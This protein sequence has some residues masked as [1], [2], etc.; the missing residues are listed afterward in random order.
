MKIRETIHEL[1][2]F[3]LETSKFLLL[4][5]FSKKDMIS[6]VAPL[7]EEGM[8]LSVGRTDGS[9]ISLCDSSI[10]RKHG[11]LRVTEQGWIEI[12]D[13][14][15]KYGTFVELQRDLHDLTNLVL[16]KDRFIF[17]LDV[18]K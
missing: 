17:Y 12:R 10:S 11:S 6:Y 16:A 8:E 3:S 4:E 7:K 14:K 15:S 1:F 5:K 9:D 2:P 18:Q 13:N